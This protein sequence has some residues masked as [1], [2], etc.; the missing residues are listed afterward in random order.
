MKKGIWIVTISIIIILLLI[1]WTYVYFDGK[2]H[3]VKV[4]QTTSYDS[5]KQELVI[6]KKELMLKEYDS[7][8][9]AFDRETVIINNFRGWVITLLVLCLTAFTTLPPIKSKFI[10]QAGLFIIVAFYIL[11]VT[12]RHIML[13]MLQELRSFES[14]FDIK[15]TNAFNMAVI[16]YEFRDIRDASKSLWNINIFKAMV[17][18]KVIWWNIFLI[19][20]Y[21]FLAKN[22]RKKSNS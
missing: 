19:A 18:P 22:I 5:S 16:N 21:L 10:Y 15:N 17:D 6:R 13:N 9:G 2:H 8:F 12:E 20:F 14:I 4:K 3:S 7:L 1:A 11:E